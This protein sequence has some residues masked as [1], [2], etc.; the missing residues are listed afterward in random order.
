MKTKYFFT[1]CR[2]FCIGE[3]TQTRESLGCYKELLLDQ[4]DLYGNASWVTYNTMCRLGIHMS[5]LSNVP[6]QA[7]FNIYSYTKC[8]E[9]FEL[10][11]IITFVK[12]QFN[13]TLYQGTA[14]TMN[15]SMAHC[16]ESLRMWKKMATHVIMTQEAPLWSREG[17]NMS[18]L[19]LYPKIMILRITWSGPKSFVNIV[20]SHIFMLMSPPAA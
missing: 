10:R 9:K 3:L 13:S 4:F 17:T 19:E 11:Y 1:K 15:D 12:M 20:I 6:Q 16:L 8:K 7:T 5:R 2:R 18:K 14:L